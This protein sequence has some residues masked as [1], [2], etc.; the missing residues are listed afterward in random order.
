MKTHVKRSTQS[1]F[2]D[3]GL[4]LL[5]LVLAGGTMLMVESGQK[6][7]SETVASGQTMT[8]HAMQAEAQDPETVVQ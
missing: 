6:K 7:E 1:G 5:V 4:S 3:L 2:F 8:A